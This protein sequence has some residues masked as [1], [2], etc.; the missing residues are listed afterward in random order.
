MKKLLVIACLTA[1]SLTM[2]GT[3][4]IPT[5]HNFGS[6]T[7]SITYTGN[8]VAKMDADGTV[9]TCSGG[10]LFEGNNGVCIKMPQYSEVVVSPAREGLRHFTVTHDN[11]NNENSNVQL[12]IST[13]GSS[14][15]VI[16]TDVA[17]TK[18]SASVN[19]Y[20]LNGNYF[21]KLKNM[22]DSSL[23]IV[24]I[25]TITYYTEPCHCLQVVS[26]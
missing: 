4:V 23:K 2:W 20:T 16:S 26:E 11:I 13:D 9:Y 8:T 17:R 15:T 10:A 6:S 24:Y 22:Y 1:F 5:T 3:D 18:T 19:S 21:V 7:T 25:R 12:S 14:W